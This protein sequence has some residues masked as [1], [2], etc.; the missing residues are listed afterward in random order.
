MNNFLQLLERMYPEK[1]PMN[2]NMYLKNDLNLDSIELMK[3]TVEVYK[4][5]SIDL[6]E[7]ADSGVQLNTIED[8]EKCLQE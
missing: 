1:K 8:V 4:R 7:L 5:F 6:G 3:I 2:V